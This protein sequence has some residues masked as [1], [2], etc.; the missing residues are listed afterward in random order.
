VGIEV[1]I[2]F[3]TAVAQIFD[4]PNDLTWTI[5]IPQETVQ[6]Y[7][8][9]VLVLA[10][11][12]LLTQQTQIQVLVSPGTPDPA[13]TSSSSSPMKFIAIGLSVVLL[14]IILCGICY[15]RKAKLRRQPMRGV[16][17]ARPINYRRNNQELASNLEPWE[18]GPLTEENL[19]QRFP[20]H[21]YDKFQTPFPQ[22][23]C[24]IC[25]ED[26][27]QKVVCR[28]LYCQHIFHSEC[29]RLWLTNQLLKGIAFCPNCNKS[30]LRSPHDMEIE[31]NDEEVE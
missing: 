26:F 13:S 18:I 23:G 2:G 29:V 16:R 17:H 24:S 5:T 11:Y 9:G 4:V 12:N 19:D 27:Q 30:V 22:L 7:F 1:P 31:E 28:Q 25:L 10:V 6:T 8:N 14:L 20:E 15:Y 21:N 3:G